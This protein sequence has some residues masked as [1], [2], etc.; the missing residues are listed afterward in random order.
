M[1]MKSVFSANN[2]QEGIGTGP[3]NELDI[4]YH[5]CLNSSTSF[6]KEENGMSYAEVSSVSH[7]EVCMVTTLLSI[8]FIR[9]SKSPRLKELVKWMSKNSLLNN[10]HVLWVFKSLSP[11]DEFSVLE[12]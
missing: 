9:K 2:R 3:L 10:A 4:E 12:D 11:L 5:L 6:A 8:L 7:A 1:C